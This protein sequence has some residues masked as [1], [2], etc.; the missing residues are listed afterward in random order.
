[1]LTEGDPHLQDRIVTECSKKRDQQQ[2]EHRATYVC[3]VSIKLLTV[4]L[5]YKQNY[6]GQ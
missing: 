1:M 2:T 4:N 6:E 3:F 5:N